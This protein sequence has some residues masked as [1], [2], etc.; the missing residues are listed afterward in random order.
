MSL[1]NSPLARKCLIAFGRCLS[2]LTAVG[3]CCVISVTWRRPA[4]EG[5]GRLSPVGGGGGVPVRGVPI[6]GDEWLPPARCAPA[7]NGP[8][9]GAPVDSVSAGD[10]PAGDVLTCDAPVDGGSAGGAP[11]DGAPCPCPPLGGLL[12]AHFHCVGYD[13]VSFCLMIW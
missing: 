6:W 12:A 4:D 11:V 10:S 9:G 7:G 2:A 3:W 13:V 8:A 5:G 1:N